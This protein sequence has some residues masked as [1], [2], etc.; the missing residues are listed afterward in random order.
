MKFKINRKEFLSALK[1][2]SR[3][4]RKGNET[5]ITDCV[6]IDCVMVN[7]KQSGQ[8]EQLLR[9]RATDLEVWVEVHIEA[10]MEQEG[11]IAPLCVNLERIVSAISYEEVIISSRKERVIVSPGDMSGK[12]PINCLKAELFPV[13]GGGLFPV[14]GEGEDGCDISEGR[15][16]GPREFLF[17]ND[18]IIERVTARSN[19]KFEQGGDLAQTSTKNNL[20]FHNLGG[21]KLVA[22]HHRIHSGGFEAS[23]IPSEIGSFDIPVS[24]ALLIPSPG[25]SL[26]SVRDKWVVVRADNL[27]VTIRR[28]CEYDAVGEVKQTIHVVESFANKITCNRFDLL[29]AIKR[30]KLC[31]EKGKFGDAVYLEFGEK[32]TVKGETGDGV[33]VIDDIVL[34]GEPGQVLLATDLLEH[35]LAVLG[36]NLTI[37]FPGA[38]EGGLCQAIG[39]TDLD[40]E[41]YLGFVAGRMP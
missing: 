39:V 31:E 27:A 1:H 3:L 2:C 20:L 35:Q 38:G 7:S 15:R 25:P 34:K 29:G 30:V 36:D 24:A 8:K 33:E 12:Y 17:E 14:S 40:N 13:P 4:A 16:E 21:E 19:A 6:V 28:G 41:G 23:E 10:E 9:L 37:S 32:L 22:A 5:P 11:C 26:I 18:G